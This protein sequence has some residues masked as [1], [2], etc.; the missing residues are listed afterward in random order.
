M[1]RGT[2]MNTTTALIGWAI[3][4]AALAGCRSG[5]W[6]HDRHLPETT[7]EQAAVATLDAFHAAAARA[8]EVTY[9]DLL[10]DNAVFMGTDPAE[11]WTKDQF[12][13]WADQYFQRDSAWTYHAIERHVEVGPRAEIAWF[14]EVVR[15]ENYGDLR[16][17]GVL[18][19]NPA[20]GR[21]SIERQWLIA[22]YN[23]TFM[24]PNALADEYLDMV[25]R[26]ASASSQADAQ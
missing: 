22:Q 2:G 16:G 8:D 7:P 15:N 23:L 13:A 26:A 6:H 11:R 3:A 5:G 19:R 14:D 20:A 12:R 21:G 24:V 10:S 4:A 18:V 1:P 25:S 9:F 17:T